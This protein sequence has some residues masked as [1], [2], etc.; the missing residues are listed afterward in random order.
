MQSTY[1]IVAHGSKEEESRTA[2][3]KLLKEV[4]GRLKG[5]KVEGA[6]LEINR[7]SIP[8]AIEQCAK[9]GE[10]E[11]VIL[12]LMMFPGRHVKEHIPAIIENAKAKY[13]E[14]D[15]HYAK[16]LSAYPAMLSLIKEQSKRANSIRKGKL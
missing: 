10:Q 1:L 12:P 13:P 5:K 2:F 6:F 11:I 4:R 15:F 16:P 3:E 8:E 9:R 7:P 14:I